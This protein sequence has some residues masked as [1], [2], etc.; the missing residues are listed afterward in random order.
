M[1]KITRL[2]LASILALAFAVPAFA[3]SGPYLGVTAGITVP[4]D[5]TFKDAGGNVDIKY[6]AGYALGMSGGYSFDALRVEGEIGYK[7]ADTRKAFTI[8]SFS[9][10]STVSNLSFMANAFYD[11]K[12]PYTFGIVPYLGG[13]IGLSI[14]GTTDGIL[15][16]T[17][18]TMHRSDD[19]VFAYQVAVGAGYPVTKKLT[20]DLGYRYFGTTEATL[21]TSV[22]TTDKLS[23]ASHN[24]LAG[25][26]YNF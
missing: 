16:N 14:L 24:V 2:T 7:A 6:D 19:A 8:S 18:R 17:I 13:G 12:T 25:L 26:R 20:L 9:Y 21:N 10:K 11:I 3:E 15:N 22:N 5:G 1:K 4:A 23:F